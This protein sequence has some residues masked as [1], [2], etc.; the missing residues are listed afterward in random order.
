MLEEDLATG[1][2]L[3]R[4]IGIVVI[5]LEEL[6]RITARTD[7]KELVAHRRNLDQFCRNTYREV[8]SVHVIQALLELKAD[9]LEGM[10]HIESM[11]RTARMLEETGRRFVISKPY[12]EVHDEFRTRME[13]RLQ[14]ETS[15]AATSMEVARIG[16]I[17]IGQEAAERFVPRTRRQRL[18]NR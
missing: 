2:R 9:D 8:V 10:G 12:E 1:A 16:E 11:A 6:P 15:S 18:R 3:A 5:A 14:E 4:E 17:L 7:A 13:N